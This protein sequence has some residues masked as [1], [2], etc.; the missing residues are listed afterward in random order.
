MPDEHADCMDGHSEAINNY[1]CAD[2]KCILK[3]KSGFKK[4]LGAKTPM[5]LVHV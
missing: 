4:Y 1:Y 2:L 3:I 5:H